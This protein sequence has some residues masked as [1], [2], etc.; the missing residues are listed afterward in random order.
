[1]LEFLTNNWI[2]LTVIFAGLYCLFMFLDNKKGG[3][4][5]NEYGRNGNSNNRDNRNNNRTN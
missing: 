5:K 4:K 2:L 3:K 1:M